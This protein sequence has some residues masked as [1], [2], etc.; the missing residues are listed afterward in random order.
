MS[1]DGGPGRLPQEWLGESGCRS[2]ADLVGCR[3]MCVMACVVDSCLVPVLRDARAARDA[4]AWQLCFFKFAGF[5]LRWDPSFL[6]ES[7]RGQQE[8]SV[9]WQAATWLPR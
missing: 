6:R 1:F 4:V 7:F 3:K 9:Q 5:A 2:K 8:L